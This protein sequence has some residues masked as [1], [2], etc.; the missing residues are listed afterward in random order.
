[1]L[2]VPVE[3]LWEMV[4]GVTQRKLNE[5][6]KLAEQGGE[7]VELFNQLASELQTDSASAV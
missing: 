4:P 2:H 1:M 7:F 5:W 3:A 6:K